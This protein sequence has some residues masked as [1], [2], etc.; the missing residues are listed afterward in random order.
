MLSKPPI[1]LPRPQSKT[2]PWHNVLWG[3]EGVEQNYEQAV[4]WFTKAAEQGNAEAQFALGFCYANGEGIEQN[5]EQAVYWYAKAAEQDNM[6][7]LYNLG[8]CYERGEG[9]E[10]NYDK[11]AALMT[12]VAGAYST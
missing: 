4:Y 5:Y 1:G 8:K 11:A 9:A 2:I 3:T 12:K 7:A 10:Q 6:D